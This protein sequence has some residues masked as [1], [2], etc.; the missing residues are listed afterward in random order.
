MIVLMK[1]TIKWTSIPV[2]PPTFSVLR[3]NFRD[4]VA[5]STG[6]KQTLNSLFIF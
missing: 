3:L 1:V 6:S 4:I 5:G 2:Y